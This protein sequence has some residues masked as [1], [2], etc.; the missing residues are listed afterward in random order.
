MPVKHLFLTGVTSCAGSTALPQL[1]TAGFSVTA[2]VRRPAQIDGCRTVVGSL[3]HLDGAA[4]EIASCDAIV[5]LASPRSLDPAE[6]L[7]QDVTGTAGLVEAWRKGPFVYA[8]S[9]TIYGYPWAPLIERGMIDLWNWYDQGKFANELQLR[10]AERQRGRGGAVLLRPALIFAVNAR[11][12]DRQVLGDIYT[13]CQLGSRF[14]FD[15]EQGLENHGCSFVG[16]ADFGRVVATALANDLSGPYNIA[17]GFC[18]WRD[19]IQMI[20]RLAGTKG[21]FVIR[22]DSKP[23]AG[24]Y[25]LPQSRT[26]LDT[27]AFQKATGFQPS[28]TLE[29]IVEAF[30]RMERA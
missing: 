28:E 10:V 21:D 15:S 20:N 3:E 22:A 16:G 11:R 27:S 29:E 13:Q 25:R 14:V 24:E 4:N 6:V 26:F 12:H 7:Q 2:L 23:Q 17:S 30:V 5:H 19:L 9:S 18:T 8:S 1:L